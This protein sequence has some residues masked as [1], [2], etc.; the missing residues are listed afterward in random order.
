M[1]AAADFTFTKSDLVA[2][3]LTVLLN[4]EFLITQ[5]L[6][7]ILVYAASAGLPTFQTGITITATSPTFQ[8]T[9]NCGDVPD[10][11]HTFKLIYIQ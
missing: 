11:T 2:G 4:D 1:I 5:P 10:G 6:Y 7:G 3:I 9:V 8:F